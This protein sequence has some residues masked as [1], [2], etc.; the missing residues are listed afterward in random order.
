[1]LNSIPKAQHWCALPSWYDYIE[2]LQVQTASFF[3]PHPSRWIQCFHRHSDWENYRA[4]LHYQRRQCCCPSELK[5]LGSKRFQ[6]VRDADEGNPEYWACEHRPTIKCAT[7]WCF[8]FFFFF[9]SCLVNS[10]EGGGGGLSL[11]GTLYILIWIRSSRSY[12]KKLKSEWKL[13]KCVSSPHLPL[14][15]FWWVLLLLLRFLLSTCFLYCRFPWY[16]NCEHHPS[17]GQVWPLTYLSSWLSWL[18]CQVMLSLLFL[19]ALLLTQL[20][21]SILGEL[22]QGGETDL[23]PPFLTP[24][25]SHSTVSVCGFIHYQEDIIVGSY[26]S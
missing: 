22:G 7:Y 12:M 11:F 4:T 23:P 21:L 25:L 24:I 9:L 3:Q 13:R 1:M 14:K 16:L 2:L 17:L 26:I 6:A 18:V 20:H 15:I 8:Q 5:V 19:L 10:E